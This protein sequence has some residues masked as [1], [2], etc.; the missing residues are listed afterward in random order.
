MNVRQATIADLP[1]MQNANLT[2]LPENYI[3]RYY[4][5][6]ALTWPQ[7]S[8]VATDASGRKIVGYVLAKMEEE[9]ADGVQ[10]GHVTSLSVM[11]TYR[12]MGIAAKLMA[13][14]LRGLADSY[15]AKY[16]SLHVRKSNRAALHLYRDTLQFEVEEVEKAYYGDGED[17]Y[18]M[19]KD[20]S[21]LED[22]DLHVE[23]GDDAY[24]IEAVEN[25]K[26]SEDGHII[27]N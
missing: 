1:G 21:L 3:F 19:K 4:L 26:L 25:L 7:A 23:E 18:A 6:H 5:Y 27:K 2:N 9:P 14:S 24:L 20:L 11:R 22:I 8:F 17:A 16:V 12:R 10:H 15:G 13:L